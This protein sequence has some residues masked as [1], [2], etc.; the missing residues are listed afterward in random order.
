MTSLH[1]PEAVLLDWD[2][3]LVDSWNGIVAAWNYALEELGRAET[4]TRRDAIMLSSKSPNEIF[5]EIFGA[6]DA[7]HGASL[8]YERLTT[9]SMSDMAVL[10]GSEELLQGLLKLGIPAAVVSNKKGPILASEIV[11]LGW[12]KYFFASVGAGDAAYDKPHPAPVLY[13]L[14]QRM[15]QPGPNVWMIGDMHSD[16][17]AAHRAGVSAVLMETTSS[18]GLGLEG[19]F[20]PYQPHLRVRDAGALLELV[21]RLSSTI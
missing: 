18:L 7:Q 17:Q 19:N 16:M 12:Q 11:H 6:D 1:P 20:G 2:S 13:A 5:L 15:I 14:K 10:P 9:G 21:N 8:F 4:K 3:T